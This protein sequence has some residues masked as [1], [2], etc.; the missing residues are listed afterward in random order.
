MPLYEYVCADCGS[1]V[2]VIRRM[3]E[4]NKGPDCV[5]CGSPETV[6]AL[7]ASA[8]IGAGGGNSCSTSAWTG[9]G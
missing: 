9:G 5:K 3:S 4:R 8:F 1:R 2:E 6:L 7:S